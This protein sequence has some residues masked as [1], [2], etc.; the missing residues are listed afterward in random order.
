M[1]CGEFLGPSRVNMLPTTGRIGT[2]SPSRPPT[3]C[4][5]FAHQERA[6]FLNRTLSLKPQ[7]PAHNPF[8]PK[9]QVPS[10]PYIS[11]LDMK[12]ISKRHTAWL[13]YLQKNLTIIN[14]II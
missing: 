9:I 10:A 11:Q 13:Q 2:V 4:C 7:S 8:H 3:T 12:E 5:G 1:T 14:T 6:R